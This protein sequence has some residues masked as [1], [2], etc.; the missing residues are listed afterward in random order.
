MHL[1][2]EGKGRQ[3]QQVAAGR[4]RLWHM[5]SMSEKGY[6][7]LRVVST[8]AR[9]QS[10]DAMHWGNGYMKLSVFSDQF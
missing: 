1:W 6:A 4:V 8:Q 5:M 9:R 10:L 2:P 7:G 3:Q